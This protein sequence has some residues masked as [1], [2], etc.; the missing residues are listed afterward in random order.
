MSRIL[1]AEITLRLCC[2]ISRRTVSFS[3]AHSLSTMLMSQR[4]I[5][6][7]TIGILQ[8]PAHRWASSS[9]LSYKNPR[10]PPSSY[11]HRSNPL[12]LSQP[13]PSPA[14]QPPSH[15]EPFA[16]SSPLYEPIVDQPASAILP[17]QTDASPSTTG[18]PPPFTVPSP[19]DTKFDLSKLPSLDID[20]STAL[21]EPEGKDGEGGD[22]RRTGA[23]RKEYISSIE[24][25]RRAYIRYGLGALLLGGLGAVYW[26]GRDD[27]AKTPSQEQGG[28]SGHLARMRTNFSDL[29]DYFNKPAFKVLLPD[30]L[31]PPHQR[32]Y[33]LCVDLE[34]LLVSSSWDVSGIMY[35]TRC[36]KLIPFNG[37]SGHMD[38]ER[39]SDP[40]LTTSLHIS[41][42]SMKLSCSLVNLST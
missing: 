40:V 14:E 39:Q 11:S 35:E 27:N 26:V 31:P 15:P 12:T 28:V 16:S 21:P 34:G 3:F 37:C 41:H 20:P 33:T 4:I 5:R 7:T 24:R 30:P 13:P 42:S 23:G 29:F 25:Q 38:G 18:I 17:V 36:C 22:R 19:S 32:P 2:H 1:M 8:R 6:H 9:P 10:S